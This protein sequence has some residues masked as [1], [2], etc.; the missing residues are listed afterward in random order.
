MEESTVTSTRED[1]IGIPIIKETTKEVI[2]ADDKCEI[3]KQ[4]EIIDHIEDVSQ[5]TESK[6]EETKESMTPTIKEAVEKGIPPEVIPVVD[7]ESTVPQGIAP[8]ITK[9]APITVKPSQEQG[10]IVLMVHKARNL[11]KKGMIGKADSYVKLTLG[12]QSTMSKTINS[13]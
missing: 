2:S 7:V 5:S 9:Q 12:E 6:K 13:N 8:L 10:T 11:Q 4:F 1:T 3:E